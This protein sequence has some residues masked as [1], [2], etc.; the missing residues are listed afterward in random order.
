MATLFLVSCGSPQAQVSHTSSEQAPVSTP[1]LSA[2]ADTSRDTEPP[3]P[4]WQLD[5]LVARTGEAAIAVH[6]TV[7]SPKNLTLFYSVELRDVDSH[8]RVM[9]APTATIVAAG[10]D[11]AQVPTLAKVLYSG[12]DV[13]LGA[14]SFG[15]FELFDTDSLHF[16]LVV[17]EL[18]LTR[19]SDGAK[20][21][22]NGPWTIPVIRRNS[23]TTRTSGFPDESWDGRIHSDHN[24]VGLSL[25]PGGYHGD[26]TIGRVATR[27]F[28]FLDRTVYFMVRPDGEVVEI[29]EEWYENVD[30]LL[31]D[32]REPKRSAR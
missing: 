11:P 9:I 29:S 20:E 19:F 13:S 31:D 17:S 25:H 26:S 22:L 23:V 14:L 2:A 10:E 30:E 27:A 3:P 1:T 8:E 5:Q 15:S 32:L 18:T 4:L 28:Y 7:M 16:T 21:T 12:V 24:L 6:H